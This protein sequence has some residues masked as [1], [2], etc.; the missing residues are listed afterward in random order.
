MQRPWLRWVLACALAGALAGALPGATVARAAGPSTN[1]RHF[2]GQPTGNHFSP[3]KQ[4]SPANVHRLHE[5]W[6]HDMPE[7]GESETNPLVIDGVLYGY[8]PDLKVIALDAATGRERWRFDAGLKGPDIGGGHRYTGPARGLALWQHGHERRLFAGVMNWLYCL[9]PA[10]GKPVASFGTGG[11][12]DLRAG[13]RGEPAAHYVSLTTP[14]MV[15]R[16]LLI[17]GFRTGESSPAPPGDVRAFDVHTGALR[18]R[19]HTIPHPG[20]AGIETWPEGAWQSAGGANNWAGMALDAQR[21]IVYAP[22]GSATSDFYGADRLGDDL[23]ANTLLAL[24]AATG[25][26]LW[27][28]QVVHHD[29]WDRD[30]P[31]AP[32]LL[33]VNRKGKRIDAV[34]QTTKQ[35]Y[36]FLFDRVTGEPLFPVVERTFPASDVPGEVASRTQPVPTLPAPYAR[37]RLDESLLTQRTPE[38]HAWALAQLQGFRSDG[39]F[40]PF[41]VGQ[42]TVV[43]PGFDGGAEWGGPAVDAQRAV[44]YI[45]A[46][47]VAWTGALVPAVAGG[48]IATALYQ[49]SCSACH[50]PDRSGSPP[51]FPSLLGVG[52]RLSDEQIAAVILN[53]RGRMQPFPTLQGYP[54]QS[55]VEYLR[56]GHDPTTPVAPAAVGG[57]D[58]SHGEQREMGVSLGAEG[59]DV[60]YRFAGY[61][62]FLDPDGY[63]AVAP[64]WGTLQAIDLDTGQ[65]L[66]KV[67]LGRYPEL[68]AQGMG[69]TGSEN[70]GGPVLTASGL[71]FIGATLFDHTLRAFDSRTGKLLWEG[72]LPHAGT[73]TPAVYSIKGKQYVVIATSDARNPK[74]KPGSAW[75]AYALK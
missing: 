61:H 45:N 23:Y 27:H 9:D 57:N 55:L 38:A 73:A 16:D 46:N 43:F 52:E 32:A 24:D 26:R 15:Y 66:W 31:S 11:A 39:Q 42:P 8:T 67:P 59:Q 6:R 53:G 65:M 75:V 48:G 37:Q 4:I 36:L 22:T 58:A 56:T 54:V 69:D 44:I 41:A 30:L 68:A 40:L 47:D 49:Q 28:F 5:V 17:V 71:L 74:G 25:R 64:P 70:Y 18:W 62:K 10:T 51:A 3:L 19:F 13:L 72:D 14:G 33:T 2:G 63:P 34:A 29:L 21:G 12:I 1:W 35:G 50:G 20:E 7:P 60:R